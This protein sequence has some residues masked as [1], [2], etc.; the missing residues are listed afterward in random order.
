MK[1][2]IGKYDE[3]KDRLLKVNLKTLFEY[4]FLPFGISFTVLRSIGSEAMLCLVTGVS[5]FYFLLT[6]MVSTY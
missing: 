6:N 2:V 5:D 1:S 4:L 3:C